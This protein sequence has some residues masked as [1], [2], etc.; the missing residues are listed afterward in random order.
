MASDGERSTRQDWCDQNLPYINQEKV[1]Q[2][3]ENFR[4]KGVHGGQAKEK[5]AEELTRLTL[6]MS[7]NQCL[8]RNVLTDMQQADEELRL[9]LAIIRADLEKS[10]RKSEFSGGVNKSEMEQEIMTNLTELVEGQE[11]IKSKLSDQSRIEDLTRIVEEM[12][13]KQTGPERKPVFECYWCH[14]EGHL[15][16]NCPRRINKGG[17]QSQVFRQHPQ[18]INNGWPSQTFQQGMAY[19]HRHNV[20][21]MTKGISMSWPEEGRDDIEGRNI[22]QSRRE[23]VLVSHNPLN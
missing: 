8:L 12:V 6:A 1:E 15:K 2:E 20:D 3:N 11:E 22:G 7:E 16:R 19:R 14:E 17:I 4:D 5:L 21:G 23:N 10:S 18:R 9:V 13:L